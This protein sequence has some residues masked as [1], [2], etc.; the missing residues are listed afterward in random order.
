MASRQLPRI[1]VVGTAQ[2]TAQL[3]TVA[4]VDDTSA[5]G[6]TLTGSNSSQDNNA[7]TGAISQI[8]APSGSNSDQANQSSSGAISLAGVINLT[9]SDA[10]QSNNSSTGS[11][12]Q[13]HTLLGADCTQGNQS[14]TGSISLGGVIDLT[15]SN[16][17]QG[18]GSSTGEIGQTHFLTGNDCSQSNTSGTGAISFPGSTSLSPADI[19]AIATAVWSKV[20][21]GFTAEE[22]MRIM[23]AALAGK[24][25]GIGSAV[26]YYM[27]TDG[28]TPRITFTPDAN[29]NG[30][31]VVNGAP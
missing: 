13:I 6:I 30:T 22:M 12:T 5:S 23:F 28:V 16:C 10:S 17:S 18:N 31:P 2:R 19:D 27:A 3:P 15:G 4:W 1:Y 14:S 8:H 7:T 24:R 26:E 25:E 29:G 11:I 9:G 21:E 20:L